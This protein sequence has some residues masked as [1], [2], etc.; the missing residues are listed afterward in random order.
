MMVEEACLDR[1]SCS[2]NR[3]MIFFHVMMVG[4]Q[5]PCHAAPS[6]VLVLGLCEC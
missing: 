5:Q 4:P 6:L 2:L 1:G 3:A